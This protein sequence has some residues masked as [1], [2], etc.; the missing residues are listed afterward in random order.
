MWREVA[1]AGQHADYVTSPE[2]IQQVMS[3]TTAGLTADSPLTTAFA[4]QQIVRAFEQAGMTD[5]AKSTLLQQWQSTPTARPCT[6]ADLALIAAGHVPATVCLILEQ[7]LRS[8]H[9]CDRRA[10][11]QQ[12]YRSATTLVA[13]APHTKQRFCDIA[14]SHIASDGAHGEIVHFLLA[15]AK[16]LEAIHAKQL[17]IDH[18]TMICTGKNES[19]LLDNSIDALCKRI[20]VAA[21]S[22]E[23]EKLLRQY[24]T[25]LP[26]WS[27]RV[28]LRSRLD[29]DPTALQELR[30]VLSH[31]I[32]PTADL[33]FF[34][35]AAAGR[36]L[37]GND[38]ERFA[39]LPK[40]LR[41][42]P[43]GEYAAAMLSLRLG[44]ADEAIQ[45][46]A[47]AMPQP[48]GRHLYELALAHLESSAPE[49]IEQAIA[50]LQLLRAN[51][52]SSSLARHAGSFVRQLSPRADRASD[53]D[54]KR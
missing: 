22:L 18:L 44:H 24:P 54:E 11:L 53:N 3:A 14:F 28:S 10:V 4:L 19:D 49:G 1:Y 46:F 34:G 32:D 50:A 20:G 43:A 6:K 40:A 41:R 23:V 16:D 12:Y 35:L 47:K 51:Y 13:E 39:R 17:L 45:R 31:A 9:E 30:M 26:L 33:A 7:V 5:L 29:D 25:S 2:L 38:Y 37:N 42:S 15:N 36:Q 48:D 21:C 8:P 27:T 52:P